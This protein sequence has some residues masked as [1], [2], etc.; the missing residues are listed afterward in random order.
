MSV[1]NDTENEH[2]IGGGLSHNP[3]EQFVLLAKTTRGAAC[4]E[5]IRQVLEA[6]GVYVFG[7][8]LTL[9]SILSVCNS[10]WNILFSILIK[11]FS[12]RLVGRH[13]S[14]G[15][16]SAHSE[17][18]RLRNVQTVS[19]EPGT[20]VGANSGDAQETPAPDHRV[21]GRAEQMHFVQESAGR[22][23]H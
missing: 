20:S 9:P 1:M 3:L 12:V 14:R 10:T 19:G 7:E 2:S 15:Q 18:V 21:D 11:M 13:T 23:G 17:A 8:L 6:P 5:L 22:T 16:V 4:L